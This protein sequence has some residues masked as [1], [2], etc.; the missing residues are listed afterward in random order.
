MPLDIYTA[1]VAGL[2]TGRGL[3]GKGMLNNQEVK[4]MA[5]WIFTAK[6]NGGKQQIIKVTAA[7]KP[8]AI[9]KGFTKA[10]RKA[11][12]DITTWNC[13]LHTA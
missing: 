2:K 7:S 11:A 1:T 12:G 4:T 8:E 6:D 3:K 5:K 9:E 13:R 10:N